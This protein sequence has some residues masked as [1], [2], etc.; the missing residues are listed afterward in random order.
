[1]SEGE[2]W[3][4]LV[5][6]IDP[7]SIKAMPAVLQSTIDLLE[8]ELAKAR[9]ALHEIQPAAGPLFTRRDEL[10]LGAVAAYR[11]NLIDRAPGFFY[12]T[13]RL[14]PKELGLVPTV[15]EVLADDD[16]KQ[17][18]TEP[19]QQHQPV[20]PV[21]PRRPS[22]VDLLS[23]SLV[24][25]HMAPYLSTSSLFALVSTSHLVRSL[26]MGT[27]YVFRHLD[28]TQCHGAKLASSLTMGSAEQ[29][30]R[31]DQMNDS[32]TEDEYYSS[33]LRNVFAHLERKSLLQDV[34]TLIL[35]GLSVPADLIAEIILTDRFN[36]NILSIRECRHLNERKLMQ[37]IN[38]A[39]RP[40]RPKGTPRV[41]GI[42]HFTPL[43][44]S[45]ATVRSKYRDWWSSRCS[46]QVS[47]TAP[48]SEDSAAASDHA[49]GNTH[50][51]NAW[52]RS[53][54]QLFK[55]SVEDG[56]AETVKKCEGIIAFDAVL[57]HG[58]RHD[59]DRYTPMPQNQNGSHPESRLLG[60]KLATVALGP[61][62]CDGCHTS[63]EGP[64]FWGQSPD[65]RFP[66]LAPPPYHTSSVAK[67]K[68]PVLIP[69][70]QPSLIVRCTECVTDRWCHRCNKWFCEDCLPHPERGRNDL[71]PHQTAVRGPRSSQDSTEQPQEH[72]C[73]QCKAD[74]QRTCRSCRGDYCVEHNEGCS[75]TMLTV[76]P[77]PQIP[78]LPGDKITLPPSALEQLLAAAP[79]QEV[80]SPGPARQYTSAFDPFN[81]H[82]F[83]AESQA[84]ERGVDRQQQLPHPLTFRIVNPQNNRVVYAGVREFS[85]A[86]NEI[87]LSAFLRGALGIATQNP[88]SSAVVGDAGDDVPAAPATVTVHAQQLPKG[89]YVRLRP[90]EAGYDPGDWKALLER[91]LRDNY[92]TLT[93]GEVLTV[94]GSGNQSFQFLVDKVEPHGTG[95][96]VID[97]DLEVDIVALTEEQ[98]R[99][100]LQKRLEKAS[101]VS[102]AGAGT[103]IGGELQLGQVVTGRVAPGDYVDYEL[104]KWDPANAL[105]VFVES[106]D[107]ADV[108]LF[109]S[110][111]S[112]RQRNRPRE[113]EHVFGDLSSQSTKRI[114]I[115]P[116]NV[117]MEGAETLYISVHACTSTESSD[118][119]DSAPRLPLPYSL[120]IH[121]GP[122]LTSHESLSAT[123]PENH[124]PGDVQCKNCHQWVPQRTLILHENFCLRNNI[125]CRQCQN[126]FQ[127]R[128]AEWQNHWHCPHDSAYGDGRIE[129]HRHNLCFHTKR[130]CGGCGFEAENLPRLAQHRT[131]VC[132]AKLILCQ[133][134]HLVV[135]QRSESDPDM[136]DPDVLVS[137]LTPHELVDGGRTTECHLCNKIIR[138][139]DMKTHLRHHDLERLSRPTPRICLNQNCGRTLDGR[140]TQ[141]A[142]N[143]GLCSICFGPLYVDTY[144]PEGK[145]LRRRVER[146]YL[147]QMM[148][149]CGKTW[150]Q[151]EY[152]KTAKQARQAPT[153]GLNSA[154][155]P[156]GAAAILTAVR[157]LLDTVNLGG[158]APNT[159]PFYLCADQVGQQRRLA[160][161]ILAAEGTI[162]SGRAYDLPWCVAAVEATVGNLEKAREWLENW[163]PA[164]GEG[165]GAVQ[166]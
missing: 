92:T 26:I 110:P 69:D 57:C 145:A 1:M 32:M 42:Y 5:T 112:P 78:R 87:G 17:L 137:G 63:P 99:E 2:L 161:E 101:R 152:C 96:C 131:T 115:Q 111:L 76:A 10:A 71:S 156:I 138:L 73:A 100:S 136:H 166:Q 22:L 79:L 31:G 139:R 13:S 9:A 77:P 29:T 149:G 38:H 153:S 163:A 37:V 43:N 18:V 27:P 3:S 140:G 35:D 157:P 130:F 61:R 86:E 36:I 24:L 40:T 33:P 84:R 88:G 114:R 129:Q 102:S 109:V 85:A 143:L 97:T 82:T 81:P 165:A 47:C 121:A 23:N 104:L 34:R 58:P 142:V 64:A 7:G 151:N 106:A 118:T 11:Q 141:D 6:A 123:G 113:D 49:E 80:N 41:K 95:I 128:S 125:L 68:R 148:T 162:V 46:R 59:V 83:A 119:G 132:P 93:S 154:S 67:A 120:Q 16:D 48:T 91:Q 127:K 134:C 45:R 158:D 75:S 44:Q 117:D 60:P 164:H 94:A 108:C 159:A 150:C 103:S 89:T 20:L 25:D 160:A 66:L 135:P 147:S 124:D 14:T 8:T 146:R 53:S 133:F 70:E 144:D 15:R 19:E 155:A 72:T 116:T 105:E 51:Q 52:Y 12:G 65:D 98:A 21:S 4:T 56:W 28:L 30:V 107:N 74:C 90:L 55:Q 126:V 122:S 54:G 62:G 39:V 50:Q